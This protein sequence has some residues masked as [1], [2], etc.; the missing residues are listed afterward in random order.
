MTKITVVGSIAMDLVTTT[1]QLPK[2]GETLFGE[3]FAM[4]PGGKGANQAVAAARLAPNTVSMLG[5]VGQDGFG[6]LLTQNLLDNGVFVDDVG[7]VPQS[8]GTAQ[9]TLFDQDNRILVC[10]GA[11]QQVDSS[12]WSK[13]WEVIEGSDLVILQNEIPHATNL[14]VA[15][16]CHRLGIPVLYNPG[17]SRSTDRE[18]VEWVTYLTPNEHEC[19]NLFP[20]QTVDQALEAH[21]NKLIVTLGSKGARFFDGKEHVSVPALK[22]QVV[23]TTGAGD[24]FNGA[25]GVALSKG[26]SLKEALSFATIASHLSVQKFGAQGGMPYLS[27]VKEH[28]AY[29]ENWI[30]E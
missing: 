28:S 3:S 16:R 17:P 15:Q 4:V 20:D 26:L 23:D 9:I 25:M 27:E 8:T 2:A 1:K 7:T 30:I 14:E 29:E 11:N 22:T 13:E 21:P 12:Q 24:T 19:R 18:M 6:P 5:L 10:S